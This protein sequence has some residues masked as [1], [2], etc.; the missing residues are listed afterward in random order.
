NLFMRSSLLAA[1][2]CITMSKDHETELKLKSIHQEWLTAYRL[3]W[4]IQLNRKRLR[5]ITFHCFNSLKTGWEW[6]SLVTNHC[7][8]PLRINALTE[9]EFRS[10]FL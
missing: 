8:A 10:W 3:I 7:I 9:L 6:Y 4:V 5:A 2:M 1:T